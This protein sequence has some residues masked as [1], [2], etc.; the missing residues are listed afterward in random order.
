MIKNFFLKKTQD[1]NQ[2][3]SKIWKYKKNKWFRY[4]NKGKWI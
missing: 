2:I 3:T 4:K 1:L